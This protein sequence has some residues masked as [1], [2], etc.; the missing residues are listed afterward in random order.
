MSTAKNGNA[1]RNNRGLPMTIAKLL[2]QRFFLDV[3]SLRHGDLSSQSAT[4]VKIA[5]NIMGRMMLS[6]FIFLG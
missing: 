2:I 3:V 6:H 1:K 5:K 4:A